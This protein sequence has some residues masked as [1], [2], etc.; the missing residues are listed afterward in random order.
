MN[1]E[2]H[3]NG[4]PKE[5]LI[6]TILVRGFVVALKLDW[7]DGMNRAPVGLVR[8]GRRAREAR[9]SGLFGCKVE[10]CVKRCQ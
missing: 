5:S 6:L 7:L 8:V 3:E 1:D 4:A 9:P 10:N 2:T